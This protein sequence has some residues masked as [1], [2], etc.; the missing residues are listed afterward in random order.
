MTAHRRLERD[1]R[2]WLRDDGHE[3][4]DRVLYAVLDQLDTTPQ[5]H[6]GWLARRFPIMHST[7]FRLGIAAAVVGAAA[8]LGANLLP[9]SIGDPDPTPTPP[10]SAQPL[11]GSDALTPGTYFIQSP[12][13]MRITFT[14]PVD[15]WQNYVWEGGAALGNTRAVC[16]TG[17]DCAPPG[18]GVGFHLVT[19]VA[20]DPCN[21]GLGRVDY[22]PTIDD[23]ASALADRPGFTSTEP[24]S[25]TIAGLP[26]RY[27]ELRAVP[28][29]VDG[30]AGSVSVFYAGAFGRGA[31]SG[32]RLRLWVVDVSGTRLVIEA[33]D[34]PST[35]D[36]EIDAAT[37]IVE[38]V[39][40][41]PT[42]GG[43]P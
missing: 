30:C 24:T 12:Y 21:P 36:G 9:D 31:T 17:D 35:P 37:S 4:A 15:G 13:P 1:V 43:S 14:V 27:V 11:A 28:G 38:S 41:E 10:A 6:A 3:D 2:S 29:Q 8:V 18:A 5:R 33:F 16:T 32:E 20:E 25:L 40:I 26:A 39:V 42:P 19:G 22:G 7:S 23:L 34:F